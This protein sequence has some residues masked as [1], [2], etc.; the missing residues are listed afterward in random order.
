MLAQLD[1]RLPRGDLW[2]Y[3]P[4]M[5]RFRGLLWRPGRALEQLLSRSGR[6]LGSWFPDLTAAAESVA[7]ITLVDGEVV[8]AD[9]S[10]QADF[11]VLQQRLTLARKFLA[12]ATTARPTILRV[13]DVLE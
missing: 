8:I 12:Q 4:K 1:A 11:G 2:A 13:F 9:E 3:E 6:V 5:D 10:S 7:R